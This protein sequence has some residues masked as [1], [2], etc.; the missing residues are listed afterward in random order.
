[1]RL[2]SRSAFAKQ[3]SDRHPRE[4][5]AQCGPR[6]VLI[7]CR[8]H[9]ARRQGRAEAEAWE[10]AVAAVGVEAVAGSASESAEAGA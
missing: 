5:R 9:A 7:G 2:G 8:R 3:G 10:S 1:M 4:D 6:V